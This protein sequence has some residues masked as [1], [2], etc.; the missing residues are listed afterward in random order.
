MALMK[1]DE[2]VKIIEEGIKESF[3][4]FFE[5]NNAILKWKKLSEKLRNPFVTI[6]LHQ[7]NQFTTKNM[8][9]VIVQN[10]VKRMK[11]EYYRNKLMK[12]YEDAKKLL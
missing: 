6:L 11:D 5:Y 7:K 4:G 1:K 3:N 12:H 9:N 2:D 8:L 10:V